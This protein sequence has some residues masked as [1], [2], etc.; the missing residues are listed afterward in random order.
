MTW[1]FLCRLAPHASVY[2]RHT[3]THT[4]WHTRSGT[5]LHT[6]THNLLGG[7]GNQKKQS[8]LVLFCKWNEAPALLRPVLAN[9]GSDLSLRA[10]FLLM[11]FCLGGWICTYANLV[12]FKKSYS[13]TRN[14]QESWDAVCFFVNVVLLEIPGQYLYACLYQMKWRRTE[15]T[16]YGAETF[17]R[18]ANRIL[19]RSFAFLFLFIYLHTICFVSFCCNTTEQLK[20]TYLIRNCR[21]NGRIIQ[22]FGIVFR[23]ITICV[24]P[25]RRCRSEFLFKYEN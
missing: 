24:Q 20:P 14:C 19:K 16:V 3:C 5:Q 9:F 17:T 8:V 15:D 11:L 22:I 10:F 4:L 7:N 23:T 13:V 18:S 21:N 25:Y 1:V 6:L 12:L 2:F